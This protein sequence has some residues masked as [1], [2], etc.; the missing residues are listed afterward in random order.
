MFSSAVPQPCERD[1]RNPSRLLHAPSLPSCVHATL[2]RSCERNCAPFSKCVYDKKRFL[3]KPVDRAASFEVRSHES[4]V[5]ISRHIITRPTPDQT[6]RNGLNNHLISLSILDLD[7]LLNFDSF[8]LNSH[9]PLTI[10]V[11]TTLLSL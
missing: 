1:S 7:Q 6:N 11:G 3:P 2:A 10:T 9:L 4:L 5:E 8:I